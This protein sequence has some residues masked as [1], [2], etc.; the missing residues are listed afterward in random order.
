MYVR[1]QFASVVTAEI[2][3]SALEKKADEREREAAA[4]QKAGGGKAAGSG[5]VIFTIKTVFNMQVVN[6]EERVVK[7]MLH[8]WQIVCC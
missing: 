6:D 8:V 1:R 2:C 3:L 7:I 4:E 5:S